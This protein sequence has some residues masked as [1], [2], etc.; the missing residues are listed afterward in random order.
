MFLNDRMQK[1]L[2]VQEEDQILVSLTSE[3]EFALENLCSAC[4]CLCLRRRAGF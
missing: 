3:Y 2:P 4:K 1:C